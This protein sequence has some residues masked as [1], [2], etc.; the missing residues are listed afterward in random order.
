MYKHPVVLNHIKE[1]TDKL[2]NYIKNDLYK[3]D[4]KKAKLDLFMIDQYY[5]E[6]KNDNPEEAKDILDAL[7]EKYM[8][9]KKEKRWKNFVRV[10]AVIDSI[11]I[12]LGALFWSSVIGLGIFLIRSIREENKPSKA[13]KPS[14]P[15]EQPKPPKP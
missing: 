14:K 8:N 11:L 4:P 15:P 7:T 6:L 10:I 2:K 5:K 3:D 1:Q 9:M 12:G 13:S